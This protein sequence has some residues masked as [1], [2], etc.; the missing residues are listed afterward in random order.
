MA[1]TFIRTLIIFITLIVVMRLMGKRQIGEMQPFE[2]IITLIVADLA[3]APMAD[4]SIPLVYGL[5]AILTLF[6]LHQL[7][8]LVEQ[9]GRITKTILSGRPSLV[10]DKNGVNIRELKK[11]NLGVDDLIESMRAMG[12][13]SLDDLFYVIFETNGKM[14]ALENPE[15]Q[16]KGLPVLIIEEGKELKNNLLEIKTTKEA[17]E[18]FLREQGS[19]IK[20]T[21]VMT[22]DEFGR[23][24][25]KLK[26]KRY[27]IVNYP[28]GEGVQC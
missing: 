6:V 27:S 21:E 12:Y 18:K 2:F 20:N 4:I 8:S 7:F 9:G 5:V 16:G 28:V 15:K 1:V 24:Y 23:T 22:V 13:F 17:L 3:C 19:S 11:N 26:D 10:V 14:S 25:L